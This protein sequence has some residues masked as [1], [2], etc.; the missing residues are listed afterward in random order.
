MFIRRKSNP[1]AERCGFPYTAELTKACV[2][3]E[4]ADSFYGRGDSNPAHPV[5][6]LAKQQ[7]GRVAHL[8]QTVLA[9][10]INAQFG[11]A[12]ETVLDAA[13]NAVHIMLVTFK[14]VIRCLQ[15]VPVP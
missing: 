9:H 14:L 7:F 5:M 4:R 13:E 1:V 10:F 11:G 15:Y 2:S 6:V 12:S 8:A 3:T